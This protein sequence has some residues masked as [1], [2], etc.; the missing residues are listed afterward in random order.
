MSDS[1]ELVQLVKDFNQACSKY[2]QGSN[3]VNGDVVIAS[4]QTIIDTIFNGTV[5]CTAPDVS[6]E[7]CQINGVGDSETLLTAYHRTKLNNCRL[8]GSDAGQHRG[9]RTDAV[10]IRLFNTKIL[11]IAKDIDTQAFGG[12]DGCDDLIAENVECEASGEV[13]MFG[14][15]TM[16]HPANIPENIKILNCNLTRNLRWRSKPNGITC[17]NLFE[18][19]NARNVLVKDTKMK[20]SWYDGQQA[21]GLVLTLRQDPFPQSVLENIRIEDCDIE[22]IGQGLDFLGR[23]DPYTNNPENPVAT[24]IT[25]KNI[26]FTDVDNKKWGNG[27][28]GWQLLLLHGSKNLT[29]DGL[30]FRGE[31]FNSFLTFGGPANLKNDGLVIKNCDFDEGMY[32]MIADNMAPGIK[33]IELYAP[34]Y[35]WEN[36]TVRNQTHGYVYPP[37]TNS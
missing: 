31:N 26:R 19:K 12:W 9:I 35:V 11:N 7:N 30:S 36:N 33:C 29:L 1:P 34:D 25:L 27:E 18:L 4:P 17:K 6:F 20:Y 10:G 16:S 24:N 15:S 37:G 5:T 8:Y 14:G 32:G 21:W 3:V 2:L 28:L 23:D 22:S 13:V